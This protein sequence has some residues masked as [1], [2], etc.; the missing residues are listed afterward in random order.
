MQAYGADPMPSTKPT[1]SVAAYIAANDPS[2]LTTQQLQREIEHLEKLLTQRIEAV[3]RAVVVAH[4]NL[5]RVPTDVD[6]AV[7]HLK[8]VIFERFLTDGI[9]FESIQQQIK[10]RDIKV[11]E[12]A[13]DTKVAVDAALSAQKELA[14]KQTET[15]QQS[16]AK[17]EAATA[18]QIDQQ[19][20]LLGTTNVAL[21]GKI[22][23]VKERLTRL[24]GQEKGSK[25]VMA[26]VFSIVAAI[27]TLIAIAIALSNLNARMN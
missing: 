18:K 12:T 21:I 4:D 6:K 26:M 25:N 20:V 7:G 3:D 27:G 5:V 14:S 8:D 22:E 13:R 10:E 16:I 19:S 9:K 17:S 15:F 1:S 11:A 23:D 24:E 2:L